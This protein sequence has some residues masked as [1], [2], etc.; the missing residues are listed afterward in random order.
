MRHG[1]GFGR[2]ILLLSLSIHS[3]RRYCRMSTAVRFGFGCQS[4]AA[5]YYWLAPTFLATWYVIDRG[6]QP[7]PAARRPGK[8]GGGSRENGPTTFSNRSARVS[9]QE[10]G[11]L[12]IGPRHWRQSW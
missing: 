10:P 7:L 2:C 12:T 6:T 9:L 8:F 5:A 1:P 4:S 3:A 11:M